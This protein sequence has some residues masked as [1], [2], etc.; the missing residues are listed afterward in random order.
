MGRLDVI[1][2][3]ALEKELRVRVAQ[4]LGGERGAMS[5]AVAEGIKLWLRANETASKKR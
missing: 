3:D 2:P 5:K 4:L 1:I